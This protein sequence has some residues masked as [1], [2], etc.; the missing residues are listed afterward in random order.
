[1]GVT[2]PKRDSFEDE[3]RN[4]QAGFKYALPDVEKVLK[5]GLLNEA[6]VLGVPPKATIKEANN[7]SFCDEKVAPLSLS[8]QLPSA[9][10]LA[11]LKPY[12]FQAA[13]ARQCKLT[14]SHLVTSTKQTQQLV[15][16][17]I[18]SDI[19]VAAD[20]HNIQ[21]HTRVTGNIGLRLVPDLAA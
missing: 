19:P 6:V 14:I 5:G 7:D 12:S 3:K 16:A 1:M 2:M 11:N 9:Q 13:A 4:C 21:Q 10:G 17:T 20:Q 8:D 18:Q 15:I